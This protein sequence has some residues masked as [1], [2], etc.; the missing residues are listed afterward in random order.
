MRS[1]Y[2]N[3]SLEQIVLD[4]LVASGKDPERLEPS[5]LSPVDEFHTGGREATV[6][7]LR[8]ADFA[9]GSRLLDIGCG[10]GGASRLFAQERG[11]RVTGID[12]TEDYVS[13][14]T[15]LAARVGLAD[16]VDYRQA[17]AVALPF[18]AAVFDGAYMRHVGMNVEDKPRLFA[19]VRRILKPG[20]T[21]AIFDVMRG[22]GEG[23][24]AF[25]VPWAADADTSFVARPA[26]YRRALDASGFQV[27]RERDRTDFAREYFRSAVQR[28]AEAGGPPPLGVHLLMKTDAAEKIANVIRNLD[29][30]LISPT[31]L[32]CR[33]RQA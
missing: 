9:P 31:E 7:F 11:C 14:A 15:A 4:A 24:L 19:E 12:L 32:I 3:R 6:D 20:G 33:A 10:I 26:D 28:A 17:S 5:D 13:T 2:A 21:F 1:H 29:K 30:A 25:P 27:M 8:Q 16:R 22:E 23:E 18:E